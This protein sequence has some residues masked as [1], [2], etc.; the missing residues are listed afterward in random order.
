MKSVSSNLKTHLS[1]EVTTLCACWHITRR[2]GVEFFFT[3]L[4]RDVVFEGNTYLAS[5]G[6]QPTAVATASD[7]SVDNLDIAGFFD[8]SAIKETELR[9]GLFDYAEV[10][11]FI[12]NYA[13]TT[14]GAVKILRGR[15]G[16]ATMSKQ[17][18]F[19]IGL[20]S[21]TQAVQ[22]VI[23]DFYDQVCKH[24][25]GDAGCTIPIN[26]PEVLRNMAYEQ[27]A[28]VKV[29]DALFSPHDLPTPDSIYY[30]DRI[31]ICTVA[32]TTD[33]IPVFYDYTVGHL[34]TDGSAV[35]QAAEAW[36]RAGVVIAGPQTTA[37]DRK[38]INVSVIDPRA[39]DDWFKYGALTWET[40]D[41]AGESVEVA[42]WTASTSVITLRLATPYV[43]QV[44]DRFRVYAGCNL[45]L[46]GCKKFS[47]VINR[48]AF[49]FIPGQQAITGYGTGTS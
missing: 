13:D 24:D 9:A 15:F 2:D 5:T 1:G 19:N 14:Q 34:T 11:I 47:N 38:S 33:T 40:G 4:D 44:G 23:G 17:G 21:L 37:A 6:Y 20:R 45:L 32:G 26:P 42:G 18:I 43:P 46:D 39:V 41:N 48:L 27:F 28:V 30:H 22:Q 7:Y 8:N 25:L 10:R 31:F 12:I 49:D 29:P 16:E 35:F 3:T 36:T